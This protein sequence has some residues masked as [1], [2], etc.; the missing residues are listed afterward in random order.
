M[1]IQQQLTRKEEELM[2]SEETIRR[3]QQQLREK[4]NGLKCVCRTCVLFNLQE[5]QM[6]ND[7]EI[8][9]RLKQQLREKVSAENYFYIY[10]GLLEYQSVGRRSM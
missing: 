1:I 4:V 6:A 5:E 3:E 7:A 10:D 2:R 8:H 9:S